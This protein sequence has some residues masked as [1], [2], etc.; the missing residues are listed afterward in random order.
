MTVSNLDSV[1]G[2]VGTLSATKFNFTSAGGQ[3][4]NI[5]SA[6]ITS[7][8]VSTITVNQQGNIA[9]RISGTVASTNAGYVTAFTVNGNNLA[10]CVEVFFEGTIANVVVSCYAEIVVN[11]SGDISIRTHQGQYVTLDVQVISNNNEDFAVLVKRNGGAAGTA[12]LNFNVYPKGDE[13]VTATST[14]PYSGTTFTHT[15]V[16][17][18]KTTATGGNPH[19]FETDGEIIGKK[20]LTVSGLT[21][22]QGGVVIDTS[23]QVQ[24]KLH[25]DAISASGQLQVDGTASLKKSLF[26]S[27]N[28]DL[29]GTLTVS[30]DGTICGKLL[31]PV[32]ST[33]IAGATF[34]NGWFRIGNSTTGIAMDNNEIYFAGAGNLGTISGNLALNPAGS[35]T[36]GKVFD[37][38]ANI[39][40]TA[41]ISGTQLRCTSFAGTTADVA[42]TLQVSGLTSLGSLRVAGTTCLQ[43]AAIVNSY[44]DLRNELNFVNPTQKFVDFALLSSNATAFG[45]Y[46]RSMNHQSQQHHTHIAMTRGAAV[47]L[48]HNNNLKAATRST[49]FYVSGTLCATQDVKVA[50]QL[51][52]AGRLSCDG[53]AH[54]GQQ[55]QVGA[56]L[57]V[58]GVAQVTQSIKTAAQSYTNANGIGGLAIYSS[59][60]SWGGISITGPNATKTFGLH[61]GGDANNKVKF[62]RYQKAASITQGGNWEA[63]VVEIDLDDGRIDTQG[64]VVASQGVYAGGQLRAGADVSAAGNL[65]IKGA[66]NVSGTLSAGKYNFEPY[67]VVPAYS[68]SNYGTIAYNSAESA[69][70]LR[71]GSDTA[72]GMTF[73]AWKV[74]VNPGNKWQITIQIRASAATTNGVYI[75]VYE[76]DSELPDGK[77]AVS[78]DVINA[79]VQEDTRRNVTSPQYENQP[80]STDWKTVTLTYTPTS[81]A[82]WGGITVLNWTGMGT[83][84]LYV[85]EP[86]VNSIL[87][88]VNVGSNVQVA[89]HVSAGGY[90]HFGTSLQVSGTISGGL[91]YGPTVR[92]NVIC[93]QQQLITNQQ[94]ITRGNLFVSGGSVLSGTVSLRNVNG[95]THWQG[96]ADRRS[97]LWRNDGAH[98][99]LL[100]TGQQTEAN[101]S[102]NTWRPFYVSLSSGA[103][104]FR[105]AMNTNGIS[106][107]NTI[108][109]AQDVYAG[110]QLRAAGRVSVDGDAHIGANMQVSGTASINALKVAGMTSLQ[111]GVVIDTSF[112]CQIVAQMNNISSSGQVRVD[113][114][115]SCGG[116]ILAGTTLRA[117]GNLCGQGNG[118]VNQNFKVGGT[119]CL[120][121]T[122]VVNGALQI[123]N[124]L[125]FIGPSEKYVDFFLVSSNGTQFSTEFRSVSSNGQGFQ[126]HL[127]F[128]RSG[129]TRLMYSGNTKLVTTNTGVYVSGTLCTTQDVKAQGQLRA[130]G[131]LSCDG[132]A[133]VAQSMQVGGSLSLGGSFNTAGNLQVTGNICC[134]G[135]I[136][137]HNNLNISGSGQFGGTVSCTG[138]HAA[139]GQIQT[140]GAVS[141]N[142]I[143]GQVGDFAQ[144]VEAAT[145]S[146][147]TRIN[148]VNAASYD[149][150]RVWNNGVYA[151]GMNNA[152]QGG[153]LSDYAM[154]FTFNNQ[155]NRGFVFR[156]SDMQKSQGAMTMNV[157]GR[158]AIAHG[159]RVGY[160]V[161][162][163]GDPGATQ[164]H[165]AGD[166]YAGQQLRAGGACSVAGGG[167]FGAAIQVG[168][169]VS[170]QGVH[171]G[172]GT[173][174]TTGV[175]SG[176]KLVA[177]TCTDF[178]R[179]AT[180]HTHFLVRSTISNVSGIYT[181]MRIKRRGRSQDFFTQY[182]S[183]SNQEEFRVRTDGRV[184]ADS[185]F[186]SGGADFAEYFEWSDGNPNVS[187]RI[188]RSVV[189]TGTSGKIGIATTGQTP[190]GV[191]TGIAGYIGDAAAFRWK[192]KYETDD[193]G[194]ILRTDDGTRVPNPDYNSACTYTPRSDR[195]EWDTIGLMGKVPVRVG[196]VLNP[197]WIKLRVITPTVEEYLVR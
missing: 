18:T 55:L 87:E 86:Q 62:G 183:D 21:S 100:F 40:T 145:V 104:H 178:I 64:Q 158:T 7:L 122:T 97:A 5:S 16:R 166:V 78:N 163:Q 83:N 126:T 182:R 173:I 23:M 162:W 14:N 68:N 49:G 10:S 111:G 125:D 35:I 120:Q 33:T 9:R 2:R 133:H 186:N 59:S 77:I 27:G 75:R 15:G 109:S 196:E 146:V 17:G 57:S 25:A 176:G 73:P 101:S 46:L 50:G 53:Q 167:H 175:I 194:R 132:S 154:T 189:I 39:Q 6:T 136:C 179:N 141:G 94:M 82:V 184:C 30:G 135:V 191:V 58:G 32:G 19:R 147:G 138:L 105:T 79:L 42:G 72:I 12:N 8:N 24:T 52:A 81:T 131:A 29:N 66:A 108:K 11:H 36:T 103:T 1:S 151:I 142:Q 159:L 130:A 34:N 85:R 88:N 164:I 96:T 102:W 127:K 152:M 54:V 38:T 188:G 113:G 195:P 129:A 61:Y 134:A 99:Y 43:G 56:Q 76:Y 71:S 69:I 155:A 110:G 115:I 172:G 197:N 174:Q 13:T 112:D 41:I 169:T 3:R 170:C 181:R 70:E 185:S 44:M 161:G 143:I 106:A 60:V 51:R 91:V 47:D 98:Y 89:G 93:A 90:G 117:G 140:T 119:T 26:V 124:E 84:A 123:R 168:G 118:F 153:R 180:G 31:V 4:I 137:G 67:G 37:S 95:T 148:H 65:I 116:A 190:F 150:I 157:S 165:A 193:Y 48:Y 160:G 144:R 114:Q 192:E 22:L 177:G 28:S 20:T 149:K 107:A 139:S 92:G 74:N 187:D 63:N 121:S 128:S 171:A 45:A 156:H 80:G